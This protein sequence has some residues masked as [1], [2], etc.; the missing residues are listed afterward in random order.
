MLGMFLL[1]IGLAALSPAAAI[2]GTSSRLRRSAAKPADSRTDCSA[3]NAASGPSRSTETFAGT[4]EGS[5]SRALAQT[6]PLADTRRRFS[7]QP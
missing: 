3:A 1:A 7:G 5:A 6:G 2:A 4:P